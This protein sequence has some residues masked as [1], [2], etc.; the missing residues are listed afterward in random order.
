MKKIGL[1]LIVI[2]LMGVFVGCG[3]NEFNEDAKVV[4]N[5]LL[6]EQERL[7]GRNIR[8][9]VS[10][11]ELE[12]VVLGFS[13]K[14][15]TEE[16]SEEER[17]IIGLIFDASEYIAKGNLAKMR[18]EMRNMGEAEFSLEDTLEELGEHLN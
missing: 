9:I 1:F 15:L 18:G 7:S 10:E 3:N 17:K 6:D 8:D 4:Y 2:M 14:H 16:S 13:E 11:D 5:F 12:E